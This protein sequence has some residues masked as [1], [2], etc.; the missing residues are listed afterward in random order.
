MTARYVEIHLLQTI[1]YANLNRD[2]LGSPKSVRFGYADRTRVSSQCWKRAVRQEVETSTGDT[3]KRTRRLP[4]AIQGRLTYRGWEPELATYAAAQVMATLATIAVKADG[5]KVDKATGEAQV[6]FYLPERAFDELADLCVQQ[7]ER[8]VGLQSGT[9]KLKK[10][11]A[12]LPADGVREVM[13]RRN[14]VIN[15]FGRMLAELPGTNVDGAV[16]VAHAFTTHATD[17]QVDFFTAVDD[18]KADADQTGSGHMNSAEFSTGTFYRYA[19]VNLDD[20]SNNLGD[21]ATA[22]ELTTAF[23]SA[24]ITAMPQAKKNS[25]APFTVPDLAYVTVRAD[26]PVSLAS[27]FETP[28]R[29]PLDSGYAEP[30]RQRLADYAGR[31]HRLIGDRGLIF[32]GHATIDD[33]GLEQLGD[34]CQ[35]FDSLIAAAVDHVRTR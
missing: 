24:F 16:Q 18:L 21:P 28:V 33:K 17:P 35:S 25:T 19:S 22:V 26:R 6:L 2:D 13:G 31:I 4:Q 8:L 27:A 30:S 23:L 1:P 20:L 32:H 15:L 12:P 9:V 5:F 10:G 11:E 14:D 29:A 7:R 3:A 34:A